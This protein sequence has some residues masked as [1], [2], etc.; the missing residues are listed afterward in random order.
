MDETLRQL[1]AASRRLTEGL[2]GLDEAQLRRKPSAE[3]FSLL[4]H[5]CHLRDIEMDGYAVRIR[6][7]L[8]EHEPVLADLDGA[9]LAIE[10]RY[11]EQKLGL[12]LDDFRR[13]RLENVRRLETLDAAAFVRRGRFENHGV[14]TLGGLLE[15]MRE[16]DAAHL[17]EI[18]ALRRKLDEESP[19]GKSPA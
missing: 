5:V 2:A 18:A 12:A 10:R 13:T 17:Q 9:Q 16:H 4:E 15:L 6:R 14:I 3:E 19:H 7:L 11:N 1:A 8:E